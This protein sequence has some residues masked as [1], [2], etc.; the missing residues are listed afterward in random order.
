MCEAAL[1]CGSQPGVALLQGHLGIVENFGCH[2]WRR[3]GETPG[4]SSSE[5]RDAAQHPVA[6]RAAPLPANKELS[7]VLRLR[8]PGPGDPGSCK[9]EQPFPVIKNVSFLLLLFLK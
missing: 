8:N 6:H 1:A 9:E 5:A 4:I 2:S 7:T 3:A